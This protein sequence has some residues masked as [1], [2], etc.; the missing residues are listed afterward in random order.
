VAVIVRHSLSYDRFHE[1]A[2]RIYR[3]VQDEMPMSEFGTPR[4]PRGLG[5]AIEDRLPGV[6]RVTALI[7]KPRSLFAVDGKKI[8]VD[9]ILATDDQFFGTFSFK[10]RRGDAGSVLDEPGEVVLTESFCRQLFGD[11]DAI[12]R[13]VTVEG[14][15]DRM[16][17]RVSGIVTDPPANSH[18]K[19]NV[20]L[21]LSTD[22]RDER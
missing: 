14:P 16:Q 9:G 17:Y 2:D 1:K 5:A 12:G 15:A 13:F 4:M 20:L 6:E 11:A 3:L 19:F 18:L 10:L 8:Y 22:E 7:T 21:S